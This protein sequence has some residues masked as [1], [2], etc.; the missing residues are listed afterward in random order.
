MANLKIM[1]INASEYTDEELAEL[2]G[3]LKEGTVID[4]RY[5]YV[6]EESEA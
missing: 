3:N 4:I 5:E 2:I 1:R 6:G